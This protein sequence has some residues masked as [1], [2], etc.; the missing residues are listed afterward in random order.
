MLSA[1][2]L[3]QPTQSPFVDNTLV[4]NLGTFPAPSPSDPWHIAHSHVCAHA[5]IACAACSIAFICC[6]CR[7]LQF[8]P[9]PA[10]TGAT[11]APR[12]PVSPKCSRSASPALFRVDV[13]NGPP[14]SEWD[15]HEDCHDDDAY[16]RALAESDTCDNSSCP[17]G[18][19]E[20]ATYTITVER[21][22]EGSEESYEQ[23]FCACIACNRSCKK[24]FLGYKIR[25]Q[26]FDNLIR[27]A[28]ANRS[29]TRAAALL[30]PDSSKTTSDAGDMIKPNEEP[31]AS[32]FFF[33][34]F[35]KGIYSLCTTNT[36]ST[37]IN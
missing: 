31:E 25:S 12:Q 1:D 29:P 6:S 36:P 18:I 26:Q 11:S 23:H 20:P 13:G 37:L 15:S 17:R 8:T 9:G 7:A 19:N 16:V 28:A 24:S 30:A 21:F 32:F 33:F 4:T 3:H 35:L 27:S 5:S 22:D 10:P 2:S 14:P 34:F